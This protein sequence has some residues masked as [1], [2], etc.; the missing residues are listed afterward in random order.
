MRLSN[1]KSRSDSPASL[2]AI[3]GYG[4]LR[5]RCRE[6]VCFSRRRPLPPS[7]LFHE[8]PVNL[9]GRADSRAEQIHADVGTYFRGGWRIQLR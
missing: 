7:I 1:A 9:P 2:R 8:S 4:A 5:H 3:D 6:A